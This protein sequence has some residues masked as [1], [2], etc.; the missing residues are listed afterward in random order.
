MMFTKRLMAELFFCSPLVYLCL[1]S[2]VC[3]FSTQD[4]NIILPENKRTINLK[5]IK[6]DTTL[7]SVS[8]LDTRLVACISNTA[9]RAIKTSNFILPLRGKRI[10]M[11]AL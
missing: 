11:T 4:Q 7:L 1:S 9:A 5:N 3:C 6:V 2:V 10:I 8:V